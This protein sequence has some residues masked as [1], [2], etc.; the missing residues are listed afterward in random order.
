MRTQ[1]GWTFIGA[2]CVFLGPLPARAHIIMEGELKG[3]EGDQKV[4][5]CEGLPRSATPY[6]FA[7]GTTITLAAMEGIPHDGYLRISF[8]EDGTDF[9]DPKSIAPLNPD[10]YG[11]GQKCLGTPE[12]HCGESDFCSDSTVLW[13]NLDPHL[14]IDVSLGQIREWTVQ[15]PDVEC[16]NCTIQVMQVMEDPAGDEHGPFDGDKDLYY[17]C[18]DV[19]L[20]KGAPAGPGSVTGPAVNTGIECAK[21][22]TTDAGTTSDA[23]PSPDAGPSADAGMS[24][25]A[26]VSADA[27]ATSMAPDAAAPSSPEGGCSTSPAGNTSEG[28]ALAL[29]ALLAGLLFA[30]RKRSGAGL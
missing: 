25:D 13:D 27:G 16:D 23:G 10:R 14:G 3:R 22:G 7:P 4:A 6:L 8:D 24:A 28:H 15:L 30:R 26:R 12:D 29:S 17:R 19:I 1:L 2:T 9:V 5:P 21:R 18:I 11:P 20:K